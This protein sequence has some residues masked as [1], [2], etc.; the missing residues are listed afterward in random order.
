[1]R[2]RITFEAATHVYKL[3]KQANHRTW[4]NS[5]QR[6]LAIEHT[7]FMIR[8]HSSLIRIFIKRLIID[9]F[10]DSLQLYDTEQYS[11]TIEALGSFRKYK[12]FALK[13][14]TIA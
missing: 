10:I 1:M 11:R 8:R 14:H 2:A 5:L 3:V 7:T 12:E 4:Q 6:I 9:I 13:N